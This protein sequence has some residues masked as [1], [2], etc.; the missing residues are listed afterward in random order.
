[1]IVSLLNIEVI[2][3]LFEKKWVHWASYQWANT[4]EKLRNFYVIFKRGPVDAK[5]DMKKLCEYK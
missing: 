2:I 1:M 3:K 5:M 4:N